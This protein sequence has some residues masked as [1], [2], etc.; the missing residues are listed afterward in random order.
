MT[1]A[2]ALAQAAARNAHDWVREFVSFS[3]F[4][5]LTV[6]VFGG[7]MLAACRI[8]RGFGD[9]SRE[10]RFRRTWGWVVI[11][12]QSYYTLGYLFPRT[13]YFPK[14]FSWEESLP[15]QLCDLAAFVAGA[16]MVWQTRWL[17]T[18][19][20]FWGIGLS[21]QAFFTPTLRT[22]LGS[23][24][25]WMFWIGH[26]MIV[27][28]AVYDIV[29]RRYRPGLRD[30]GVA[31]GLTIA[32]AFVAV[33]TNTILD[34]SGLLAPG[35]VSNYGYLGNT[36]PVNP[37]IIDDLGSWPGRIFK[38]GGIVMLDFVVLWGVWRVAAI[39]RRRP[40]AE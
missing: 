33:G 10:A 1:P 28:S 29:V 9:L 12:Y 19:L 11:A 18:L 24:H 20:Y 7:T 6:C 16:A 25:Y 23:A 40:A 39:V 3:L 26:T 4:H 32:Y 38:L 35:V 31:V 27:G 15:L 30:L 22:G 34:R 8:G 17:R 37:T 21:T 36:R 13:L 2:I 14:A 5:L